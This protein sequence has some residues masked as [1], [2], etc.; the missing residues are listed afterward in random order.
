MQSIKNHLSLVIALSS[1]IFSLQVFTIVDRSITAYKKNLTDSYSIVVVSQKN[2]DEKEMLSI[3]SLIYSST[4]L[5]PDNVIERLNT[6]MNKKNTELL[7][8]TLPKFYKLKL[9]RY[10][11]PSEVKK[12]TKDILDNPSVT[13]VEDFAHNHDRVYKLLLMFK[14]VIAIFA[15]SIFVITILLI[16]KE[17]KIWQFKHSERMSIMG[18]FGAPIW[19][20]SAVLF[21]LAIVDAVV[22]SVLAFILFTYLS[23]NDWVLKQFE[24][25]GINIVIFDKINDFMMLFSISLFLSVLLALLIV[26]GHKEEV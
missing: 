25:I 2:I 26:I 9:I 12:L 22:S 20:R 5:T 19:L 13:K 1:I 3:N 14:D 8:V 23:S 17:L 24:N 16:A 18:L 7:K 4:E 10:P 11:S 15:G 6:D 21:R